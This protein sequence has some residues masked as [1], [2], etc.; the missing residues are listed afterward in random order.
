MSKFTCYFEPDFEDE[1]I[2]KLTE[3]KADSDRPS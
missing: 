2:K 3:A 1:N